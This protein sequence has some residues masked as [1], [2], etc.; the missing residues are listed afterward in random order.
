MPHVNGYVEFDKKKL[1]MID[2]FLAFYSLRELGKRSGVG[3]I[4]ITN[5]IMR[6]NRDGHASMHPDEWARVEQCIKNSG[7]MK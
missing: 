4:K 6:Y 2:R 5:M 3:A 1:E 7:V